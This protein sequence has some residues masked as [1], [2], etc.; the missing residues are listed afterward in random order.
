MVSNGYYILRRILFPIL[1]HKYIFYACIMFGNSVLVDKFQGINNI[2]LFQLWYSHAAPP[3]FQVHLWLT[4]EAFGKCLLDDV[5]VFFREAVRN[6]QYHSTIDFSK[7]QE[8][9]LCI[10]NTVAELS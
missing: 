3:I 6:Y 4:V 1:R 10:R 9:A 5:V 7:R 8:S 2:L